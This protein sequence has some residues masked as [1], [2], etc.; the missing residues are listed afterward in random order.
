MTIF[1]A[2]CK[3]RALI[4]AGYAAHIS[5]QPAE[6]CPNTLSFSTF[7]PRSFNRLSVTVAQVEDMAA[8][9]DS[10][11]DEFM[12]RWPKTTSWMKRATPSSTSTW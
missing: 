7:D 11:E 5:T 1:S 3:D 10:E 9:A 2:G 8:A 12:Q 4:G 6:R